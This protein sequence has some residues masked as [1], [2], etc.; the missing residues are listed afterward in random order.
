ML[1]GES[2]LHFP[3]F[4]KTVKKCD[5]ILRTC[6][7]HIIDVLTSTHEAIFNNILN[8]LVGITV[9]QVMNYLF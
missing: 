3:T 6:G 8:S 2:L 5:T 1:T 4:Y 9:M 7:M